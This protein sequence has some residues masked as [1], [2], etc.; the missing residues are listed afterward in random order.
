MRHPPTIAAQLRRATARRRLR[1]RCRRHNCSRSASSGQSALA[2]ESLAQAPVAVLLAWEAPGAVL[3]APA[4]APAAL[5][6]APHPL[7]RTR[8]ARPLRW[9]PERSGHFRRALCSARR[10]TSTCSRTLLACP[11]WCSQCPPPAPP[12][13]SR[14]PGR[15]SRVRPRCAGHVPSADPSPPPLRRRLRAPPDA[16][17]ASARVLRMQLGAACR[18]PGP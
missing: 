1:L 12:R 17:L 16:L 18:V 11:R 7:R 9:L 15:S 6:A 10:L 3:S 2:P 13:R 4:V 5:G 14:W 8:A